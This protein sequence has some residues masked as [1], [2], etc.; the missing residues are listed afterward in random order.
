MGFLAKVGIGAVLLV[1][2]FIMLFWAEGRAVK[3]ARALDEGAGLVVEI[4][5]AKVDTAMEGKLIHLSGTLQPQDTPADSTFKVQA[6]GA[7]VLKRKVEMYQWKESKVTEE[8]NGT[9]TERYKYEKAWSDKPVD[10]QKFNDAS[11][12]QNPEMFFKS[13]SFVIAEGKV[14]AFTLIGRDLVG[15]GKS[16]PLPM[17]EAELAVAKNLLGAS[18]PVAVVNN[19]L[20]QGLSPANPMVGDLRISFEKV[21]VDKLSAVGQQN[22]ERLGP[23]KAS[24]G[25][26]LFLFEDEIIP[27][28]RMFEN[29]HASNTML[30]W[31]LRIAGVVGMFVGSMLVSSILRAATSFIPGVGSIVAAGTALASFAIA[32]VFSAIAIAGGWIFYRP[33]LAVAI[34]ALAIIVWVAVAFM[35][36]R[37]P[38][39]QNSAARA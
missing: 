13:D 30:T 34:L 24:N 31:V 15:L 3:Q 35:G 27:A 8:S 14:G 21:I 28:S 10:S 26:E 19:M 6:A 1:A 22:G 7:T 5:P 33:L 20:V 29:A 37:N 12:H 9:K 18:K 25:N 4:D 38:Q 17:T 16:S 39:L 36:K 23:F 11:G 32:T 2:A